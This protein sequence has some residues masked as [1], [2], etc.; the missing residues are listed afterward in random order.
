MLIFQGFDGIFGVR[1]WFL[2]VWKVVKCLI[3][4]CFVEVVI[5]VVILVGLRWNTSETL[6]LQGVCELNRCALSGNRQSVLK[7]KLCPLMTLK[8]TIIVQYYS[9]FF[10][11]RWWCFTACD[12]QCCPFWV[13]CQVKNLDILRA[14][15]EVRL[16]W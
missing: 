3:F 13:I 8:Y 9:V 14:H 4:Q 12:W 10:T 1:R 11:V 15:F 7:C 5:E 2:M 16:R 6:I